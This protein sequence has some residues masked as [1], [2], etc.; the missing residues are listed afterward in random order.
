MSRINTNVQSL[1]ARRVLN[2]NIAAQNQALERLSRA[3]FVLEIAPETAPPF[4]RA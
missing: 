3:E 1:L 2:T 4:D